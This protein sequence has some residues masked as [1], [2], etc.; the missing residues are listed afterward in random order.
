MAM[1]AI[2]AEMKIRH[3]AH[4]ASD[5]DLEADIEVLPAEPRRSSA[6]LFLSQLNIPDTIQAC[7]LTQ[8]RFAQLD[9]IS[10]HK[11]MLCQRSHIP[12]SP[13]RAPTPA[14]KI[15]TYSNCGCSQ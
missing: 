15:I 14:K 9:V 2:N 1:G 3:L 10:K 13:T 8:R 5:F 7:R 6:E 4:M 11:N 12:A